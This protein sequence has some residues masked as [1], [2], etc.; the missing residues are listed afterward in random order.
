[1]A[2]MYVAW[3]RYPTKAVGETTVAT[4]GVFIASETI[5]I[6][7]GGVT[8]QAPNGAEYATVWADVPFE[9]SAG[10]SPSAV[11]GSTSMPY[12]AVD[13]AQSPNVI[14]GSTRIAGIAI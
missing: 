4:E 7:A 9:F 14:P 12:P 8:G 1:M 2:T 10:P 3:H 5:D 13:P 11:K 6:S